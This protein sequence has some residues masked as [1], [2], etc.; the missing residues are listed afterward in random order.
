MKS[1]LF[2]HASADHGL[3]GHPRDAHVMMREPGAA[4]AVAH[5]RGGGADARGRGAGEFGHVGV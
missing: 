2:L 4:R 3:R 1:P 5:G